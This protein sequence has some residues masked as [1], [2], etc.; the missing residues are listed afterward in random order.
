MLRTLIITYIF[1]QALA[2]PPLH[3]SFSSSSISNPSMENEDISPQNTFTAELSRHKR[4]SAADTR[5]YS[6]YRGRTSMHRYSFLHFMIKKTNLNEG[7]QRH[8][9]EVT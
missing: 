5:P 3:G 4:D 9:S 2:T 1:A 8:L 6:A 7:L